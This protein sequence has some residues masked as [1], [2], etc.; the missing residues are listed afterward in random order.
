MTYEANQSGTL[1]VFI[2]SESEAE[3][4]FDD[5]QMEVDPALVVQE[6]HYYPFGLNLV[7][8]EK[9]G[10]P[11]HKFQYNGKEKQEEFSLD[12]ADYG[13][14]FYDAQLGRFST[15]DPHAENYHDWNP[16]NY[17]ANNPILMVD[18]DGKDWVITTLKGEGKGGRDLIKIQFTGAVIDERDQSKLSEKQIARREKSVQKFMEQLTKQIEKSFKGKDKDYE[19]VTEAVVRVVEDEKQ[20]KENDHVIRLVDDISKVNSNEGKEAAGFASPGNRYAYVE[21]GRSLKDM[22]TTGAHEL[23]HTAFLGHIKDESAITN[24]KKPNK[25]R[26]LTVDNYP[27]NLMH[28]NADRNSQEKAVQGTSLEAWQLRRILV[29]KKRLNIGRQKY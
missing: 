26:Q 27:G 7:G 5:L 15:I 20:V 2:A 28:Q 22:V 8:I 14:R 10:Q 1:Q 18:P 12:W 23:G 4:W 17:V 9:Q 6:N 25:L 24:P 13:A 16:Y 19:F 29:N 21:G 11:D 3:V